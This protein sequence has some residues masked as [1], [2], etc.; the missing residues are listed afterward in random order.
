MNASAGEPDTVSRRLAPHGRRWLI[1]HADMSRT[2]PSK[3]GALA[4]SAGAKP[5]AA[6]TAGIAS[7][8]HAMRRHKR[9]VAEKC[10]R[11]KACR[12]QSRI[13]LSEVKQ[14]QPH[15]GVGFRPSRHKN[16]IR[17]ARSGSNSA[18][19][20]WAELGIKD[21]SVARP[22]HGVGKIALNDELFVFA[23]TV[24]ET[25]ILLGITSRRWGGRQMF[26]VRF[27]GA[28]N[29]RGSAWKE[30]IEDHAQRI[31]RPAQS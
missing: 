19:R 9:A 21:D 17:R 1:L 7:C 30:M 8:G 28:R 12:Q 5:V 10:G 25:S 26:T 6:S 23:E 4:G 22:R 2:H 11:D 18:M 16:T 27:A 3:N 29:V 24:S 31:R 15:A 14:E 13:F 20:C